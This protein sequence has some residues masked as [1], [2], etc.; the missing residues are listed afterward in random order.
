MI[1]E[2]FLLDVP[3]PPSGG[4]NLTRPSYHEGMPSGSRSFEAAIFDMDGLLLE[5]ESLWRKA[6]SE[7]VARLGLPFTEADFAETTGVRMRDVARIWFERHPWQGPSPDDV[8]DE[9]IDRVVELV[10]EAEPLAGVVDTLELL[11][12]RGLRLALCSSSDRRLIDAV[13]ATLD[14]E[15]YFEVSH[16]AEH[17]EFGK[18]HPQPYLS[19]AAKLGITPGECLAFEDSI[20]GCLA[21]KSAGMKVIAVPE[22]H[23]LGLPG[24]GIADVVLG[25]LSRFD[26]GILEDVMFG[27]VAP[28]MARPRFHLAFPVDDLDAAR[29]FYIGVLGCRE[30]R[31]ADTWVDFEL[32]GHQVVAH[33]SDGM[34]RPT[35][36]AVDGH[37]VPAEHFGVLLNRPAWTDVVERLERA[38]A[39]FLIE[40]TVRF[41]GQAG[42]Q[43]TC[44][45]LDPAGNAIEFK[46]FRDDRQVFA[47]KP[48]H[49]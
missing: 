22:L 31:S 32:W 34:N 36:N 47:S 23:A 7:A 26:R 1:V 28:N 49:G 19:T 42:E 27:V 21:A 4:S 11:A 16:S 44:F 29:R 30:G 3:K 13:L 8:A 9:V 40:P 41:A 35:T 24:F 6:Q 38:G 12:S 5:S 20:A 14:L 18:P 45:V 10:A 43:H 33:L 48:Q 39:P 25:S 2:E 46:A 17:D 37:D 15:P